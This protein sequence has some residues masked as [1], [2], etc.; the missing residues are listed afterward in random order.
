MKIVLIFLFLSLTLNAKELEKVSLQL[1]WFDQFQFAGY[2]MAKEKG[3]YKELGLEVEIK[4]FSMGDNVVNKVLDNEAQYATGRSSLIIDRSRGKKVHLLSA[5]FQTSPLVLISKKSSNINTIKDFQ[6]KRIALSGTE[7]EASIFAMTASE[8]IYSKD[9]NMVKSKNKI[10][11]LINGEVEVAS[12]Y[13][14]NQVYT[15]KNMGI[16]TNVFNPK[17][18]GFDFYSD[19]LFTSENEIRNHQQRAIDFRNASLKGWN[20]AFKHI[21]ETIELIQ[22][23]Y[24]TQSKS[25]EALLYEANELKK[26]AYYKT[27]ELGHIEAYKIQRIYDIYNIMG[28]VKSKINL[29]EFIYS[30]EKSGTTNLTQK[31]KEYLKNKKELS[32]C[33]KKGWLP[34]ESL[35]NDKFIGISADFLNLYADKLSIPLKIIKIKNQ[36]DSLQYLQNGKCDLKPMISSHSKSIIPYSS[37]Q[38]HFSDSITLVTRIEEPFMKDLNSLNGKKLVVAKGFKGLQKFIKTKYPN[39]KYKEVDSIH[40]ALNL[41]AEGEV[42]GYI[43]TALSSSYH[44]QKQFSGKL[45]IVNDFE[46]LEFGVGVLDKEPELLSILNKIM[47]QTKEIEKRDIYNK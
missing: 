21:D 6:D 41:V 30:E 8:N 3:Y 25:K 19:I 16:D 17:D 44:I 27:D 45:K 12:G 47:G 32:V 34:Y 22:E 1:Q 2:Y 18:Y 38:A 7:Q 23:K 31:E 46:S 43:G 11:D 33:V 29:E 42:Y 39:V 14:S 9:I 4:S 40:T 36:V 26:L 28:F 15:L 10:E 24:N 20:Y 35:E 37:T 13:T 5:I